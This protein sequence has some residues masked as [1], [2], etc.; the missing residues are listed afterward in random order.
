MALHTISSAAA[1]TPGAALPTCIHAL[2]TCGAGALPCTCNRSCNCSCH[3]G[4]PRELATSA[5]SKHRARDRQACTHYN[6]QRC[7]CAAHLPLTVYPSCPWLPLSAPPPCTCQSGR[8]YA[9]CRAAPAAPCTRPQ[10]GT[11]TEAWAKQS[12][13]LQTLT[14]TH[15]CARSVCPSAATSQLLLYA[16]MSSYA[17]STSLPMGSSCRFRWFKALLLPPAPLSPMNPAGMGLASTL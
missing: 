12:P 8:A 1:C 6:L 13:A 7:H 9:P 10:A 17:S 3:L 15:A 16:S 4:V 2:T 14:Q 11:R 5:F